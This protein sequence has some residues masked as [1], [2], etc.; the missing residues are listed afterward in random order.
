MPLIY[1]GVTETMTANPIG[2]LAAITNP[3]GTFTNKG[4]KWQQGPQM[5]MPLIENL[6]DIRPVSADTSNMRKAR[7]LAE[8]RNSEKKPVFYH[9][10]QLT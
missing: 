10:T 4:H 1:G 3:L 2:A 7:W 9:C 6:L 5:A 8:W